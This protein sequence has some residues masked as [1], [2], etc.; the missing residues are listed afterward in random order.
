MQLK[1]LKPEGRRAL[2]ADEVTAADIR[3]KKLIKGD[4]VGL[5]R[6]LDVAKQCQ[7]TGTSLVV[8]S[9]QVG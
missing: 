6:T 3:S 1:S 8:N 9:A 5:K 4:D 2:F 7:K